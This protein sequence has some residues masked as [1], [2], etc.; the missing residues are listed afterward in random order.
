MAFQGLLARLGRFLLSGPALGI[1]G[2]RAVLPIQVVGF[3]GREGAAPL[4]AHVLI[5]HPTE[6]VFPVH[7]E[8]FAGAELALTR[9]AAEAGQVVDAVP[10]FHDQF[11]GRYRA[12]AL[13]ASFLGTKQ[14]VK[15][16]GRLSTWK[17]MRLII[18]FKILGMKIPN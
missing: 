10:H 4:L 5:V 14:P 11:G 13:I 17:K 18:F 7:A 9:S 16:K 3:V 6:H 1:L 15:K 2:R 8:V 12:L